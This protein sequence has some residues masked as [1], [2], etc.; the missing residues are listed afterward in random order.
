MS[1]LIPEAQAEASIV[2]DELRQMQC[3]KS[4]KYSNTMKYIIAAAIHELRADV[5][6]SKFYFRVSTQHNSL[7][8]TRVK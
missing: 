7:I 5:Y 3:G 2:A 4:I 1:N 6:P 8:V